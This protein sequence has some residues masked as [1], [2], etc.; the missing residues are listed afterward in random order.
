MALSWLR[1]RVRARE[2]FDGAL[3]YEVYCSS[4]KTSV[5]MAVNVT[6]NIRVSI[7]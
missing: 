3:R 6:L 1:P 5:T 4:S 2:V 7:T